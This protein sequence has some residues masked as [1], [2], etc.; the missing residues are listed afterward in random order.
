MVFKTLASPAFDSGLRRLSQCSFRRFYPGTFPGYASIVASPF[1]CS[2][3]SRSDSL[4]ISSPRLRRFTF[5]LTIFIKGVRLF[6]QESRIVDSIVGV[7]IFSS[8]AS[9]CQIRFFGCD[10]CSVYSS[11]FTSS[12]SRLRSSVVVSRGR[13][14]SS[15]WRVFHWLMDN[16]LRGGWQVKFSFSTVFLFWAYSSRSYVKLACLFRPLVFFPVL[17]FVPFWSLTL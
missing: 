14:G 6:M 8:E 9:I 5:K 12:S 15:P 16:R 13:S 4:N 3:A 11:R 7:W 1:L 17:G 10:G 2:S